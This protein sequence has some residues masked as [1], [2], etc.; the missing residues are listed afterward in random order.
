MSLPQL[1]SCNDDPVL[2]R[3]KEWPANHIPPC[4]LQLCTAECTVCQEGTCAACAT[5]A[6]TEGVGL[7][8]G[9]HSKWALYGDGD[10]PDTLD[11]R[12]RE[13][14]SLDDAGFVESV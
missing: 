14:A 5:C 2:Q 7:G 11:E 9:T 1:K 3:S 10:E 12:V 6:V 8:R 4:C 13:G